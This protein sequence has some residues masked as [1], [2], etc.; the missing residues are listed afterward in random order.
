MDS[1]RARPH[2]APR[3]GF[4]LIELL[5]VLFVLALVIAGS[6]GESGFDYDLF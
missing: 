5:A 6:G 1:A 2:R 3:A 4:T